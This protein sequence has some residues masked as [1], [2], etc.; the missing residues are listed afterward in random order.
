[1]DSASVR[2]QPDGEWLTLKLVAPSRDEI[3]GLSFHVERRSP[4]SHH[5]NLKATTLAMQIACPLTGRLN[6]WADA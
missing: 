5:S 3:L 1:L 6:H 4:L 2:C